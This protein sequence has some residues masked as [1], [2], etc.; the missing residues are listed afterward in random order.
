MGQGASTR[1]PV[2]MSGTQ[3]QGMRVRVS[4]KERY[5]GYL[6]KYINRHATLTEEKVRLVSNHWNFIAEDDSGMQ[7]AGLA[8][9]RISVFY[10]AFYEKLFEKIPE[11]RNL[12]DG[13]MVRQSRALVKMVSWLCNLEVTDDL[14]SR[15][16]A[17]ADRHVDYG[18]L[19]MHYEAGGDALQHALRA[20]AVH[21]QDPQ[22][23][24]VVMKAWKDLY[25]F[26]ILVVIPRTA[27]RLEESVRSAGTVAAMLRP[28]PM[29]G[30]RLKVL[31]T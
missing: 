2:P 20:T 29:S 21:G 14:I 25:S 13:N 4:V 12:F 26:V 1:D 23:S 18:C 17:L 5:H 19:P 24:K 6:P 7:D 10:D 9:S 15:L 31:A 11:A 27:L 22:E 8:P 28:T 16:E 30:T 3:P